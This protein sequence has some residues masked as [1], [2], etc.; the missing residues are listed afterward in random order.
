MHIVT[1]GTD[2]KAST[3]DRTW[4]NCDGGVNNS[5]IHWD[6]LCDMRYYGKMYVDG[7]LFYENGQFKEDVL[8]E[9]GE[10]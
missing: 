7:E 6:M 1:E 4:V 2:I 5:T 8:K 10:A 3:R 9:K